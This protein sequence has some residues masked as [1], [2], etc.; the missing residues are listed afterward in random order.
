MKT[1]TQY[2]E[3]IT[4]LMR[5]AGDIDAK[6]INEN[7]DPSDSEV[8]LKNEIMDTV[9]ETKRILASME[10]QER[11]AKELPFRNRKRCGIRI[12][13]VLLGNKWRLL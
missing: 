7:R 13:L 4:N 9:E 6:C 12:G 5:A 10:R 3:D 8:A 11:I 1:M 2:R